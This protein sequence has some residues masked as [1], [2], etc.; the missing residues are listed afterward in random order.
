MRRLFRV[1]YLVV[2]VAAFG[3]GVV[4]SCAAVVS[5]LPAIISA[6]QTGALILSTIET[7]VNAYFA[8]HPDA[9]AQ[10]KVADALVRAKAA[11]AAV[12]AAAQGA[13]EVD[14]AQV[15]A[16]F[17]SFQAAYTDLLIVVRPY[18]V[19]SQTGKAMLA[20]STQLVVPAVVLR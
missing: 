10:A 12:L 4:A 15:A 7:F 5:N 14:Q 3:A 11:D 6:V 16:A 2:A 13:S 8:V 19:V 17:A 1:A 9:A 18:G 20:S